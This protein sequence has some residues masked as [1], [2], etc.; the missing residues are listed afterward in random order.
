MPN[1]D[2]KRPWRLRTP[3]PRAA[4]ALSRALG[5]PGWVAQVLCHRGYSD[6]AEAKV[7]LEPT[8][9]GLPAPVGLAGLP[10]ALEVM[11][12]AVSQGQVI[13]VAGDYDA[14]GV[15]ATALVVDFL[16]QCGAQV[17]WDLPHRLHDGY[18]FSPARARRLAQAGARVVITVD[19]GISDHEGVS[20]A[21][22]L[23]LAVVVS[24]HHQIPPGPL[25]PAQAVVNPQQE[26][27]ARSRHLSG[28]G[29]AFYLA[30]GLR[31]GLRQ[32]GLFDSREMP[33][34]RHSLD[35]VALGT[36]ADVVPL[37]EENRILVS[38]GLKVINEGRRPGLAVLKQTAGLKGELDARDL[39]FMLAPRLNAAGRLEHPA[40]AL[41]LLLAETPEQ[42]LPR[43]QELEGLNRARRELEGRILEQALEMV[44]SDPAMQR[45]ACL[46]LARAGWHRGVLGIVASRLLEACGKPV[47]LLAIEDGQ[48][49]G[50]GRSL[51]GFHMQQALCSLSHLLSHFG[52]HALA[53]GCTLPAAG[54]PRLAQGLH[55]AAALALPEGAAALPWE[56]DAQ[57]ELA[58]L[59]NGSLAALERLAPFGPGNSEPL[60]LAQDLTVQ[61][62]WVVG[63]DHLKM[64]LGQGKAKASAIAF[65]QAERLPKLGQRLDLVFTPRLSNFGGRHLELVVEDMRPAGLA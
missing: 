37:L 30:A 32:A 14:D 45:A 65:R 19:C 50:S 6:P 61:A 16:R 2:N 35:L 25:V 7:F 43:A 33:N 27:C 56:L 13:G 41:E 54:L 12:P 53:A 62:A 22:E 48:A 39:G 21:R 5:L 38:E 11:A 49:V 44:E 42:A 64:E 55:Q 18:G 58:Q 46:V 29:V 51:P 8:L 34:L 26:C 9:A 36:C 28:V 17:V 3:T 59:G 60:L 15:T 1:G 47:L 31:A 23:G 4:Q 20:E 40:L 10:E 24:D 63:Q 57:V 52:G